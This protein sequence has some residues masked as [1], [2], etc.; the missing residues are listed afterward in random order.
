MEPL[1][2][3]FNYDLIDKI[4]SN[5]TQIEPNFNKNLFKKKAKQGLKNL[6]LKDRVKH[7]SLALSLTLPGNF[8]EQT[9]ILL[10]ILAPATEHINS[11]WSGTDKTALS[12][13]PVWVLTQFIED[14]GL[15]H[16]SKSIN[17]LYEMTQRFTAEFAIRPFIERYDT[18][19][20]KKLEVWKKN[21]NPHVRRLVSEGTRPLLPWGIKVN[22]INSNL[23][24]N[25]ELILSLANDPSE[26]VRRSVANHL[27]DISK[28]DEK[29]F[30]DTVTK[31]KKM[32]SE[33]VDW[34]IRHATRT[35]LKKGSPKA[36]KI[37]GYSPLKLS[38]NL[39]LMKK[40]V[41]EGDS[42]PLKL[43]ITGNSK[44]QKILVEYIIYYL[45]QNGSYSEKVFR[46]KDSFLN[47]NLIIEKEISFKKV[48]TRKHYSGKHF[49]EI[50]INGKRYDKKEF[51]FFVA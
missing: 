45:K 37:H 1:K 15:E 9:D 24:R 51:K 34:V 18:K 49:I 6:E 31:L 32:N 8:K 20:Y 33:D 16:F 3:T 26:Y 14:Y 40:T 27:N 36:L 10:N 12:G 50:Q 7:I 30:F 44:P 22:K 42:L 5:I 43:E 48:T 47:K 17:A 13:F 11:E 21:K 25:I 19:V 35:L 28:L 4:S 2:N 23:S 29:L 46:L 39:T 38:T 41:K